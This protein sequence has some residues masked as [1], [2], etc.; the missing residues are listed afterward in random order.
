MAPDNQLTQFILTASRTTLNEALLRHLAE[1]R[2]L[3]KQIGEL[4]DLWVE[5]TW[6]AELLS[7][8]KEHGEALAAELKSGPNIFA[9]PQHI[10]GAPHWRRRVPKYIRKA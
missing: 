9:L 7:W 5:E 3:R 10:H 1:A 4:L 8:V 2:N 6:Q